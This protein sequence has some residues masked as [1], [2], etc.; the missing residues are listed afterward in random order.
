MIFSYLTPDNI[1]D[2]YDAAKTHTDRLTIPFPEFER[3]ARNRAHEGIDP[4]YPKTT[5]GTTASIIRKTPK[6]IIQQL[7]TGTVISEDEGWLGVI[8]EY[9]FTEKII[10]NANDEYHLIQKCWNIIEKGLTFGYGASYTPFLSHDGEFSPDLTL[11]YWGDIFFQPGKKSGYSSNY[12]FMRAWWQKEDIEALIDKEGKLAK[13]AKKRGEQYDSSWD[14]EAL[15]KILSAIS[16]K[17][18][19]AMTPSEEER[20]VSVDGIE[21]ITGFQK[22][23]G[24]KFF[25]FNPTAKVIVRTKTN[26]D[27]RGKMPIDFM[28]G[29]VDGSNPLGRGLVELIGGLQNLIDSDMQMYQYNRALMLA[30]PVIKRGSFS[31]NK[32]VLE[33]NRIIDLGTDPS[34]SVETMKIDTSAVI[35]YP[36]LYGLQKSQLLN[37]VNSPDTSISSDVGNP[38]FS[39]TTAGVQQQAQTVSVDDNYVSKM[40]ETWFEAWAET[41]INLYFA[42]RSGIEELQLNKDTAMRLRELPGFDQSLLSLDNKIRINYDTSTPALKFRVNPSTTKKKDELQQVQS[43]TNLL[44]MVM[45]YP[46]LNS[47]YGGPIDIEVLSR[48]IVINSGIDDPEQVA[49]EPTEAQKQ[50][51]EMQKNQV[52]PFSPM[53]DK[54]SIRM[55]FPDLP[56]AA[57]IQVLANAGVHVSPE[58]MMQGPVLDP[59][60]RGVMNPVSDPNALMPGGQLDANGQ[61]IPNQQAQGGGTSPIDLG[62]IYKQTTDPQVK[63]EIEQMAGLHPNPV[64]LTNQLETNAAQHTADQVGHLTGAANALMPQPTGPTT[65]PDAQSPMSQNT[66]NPDQAQEPTEPAQ[67]DTQTGEQDPQPTVDQLIQMEDAQEPQQDN[68]QETLS[69]TDKQII[70]H[71]QALQIPQDAIMQAIHMMEQ[72]ASADQVLQAIGV[73]HG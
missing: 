68:E 33:P 50:S 47:S 51:K 10:Q 19:R 25:T 37:L 58:E 53:F 63:A 27:P 2:R 9:I 28:Y 17:D 26:K 14:T 45:K 21:L 32:V 65:Q 18:A 61:P 12:V 16:H 3:I 1:Y 71:L 11:P 36:S 8:A 70:A 55:N 13:N 15:K 34:A 52:N 41:A 69:D 40:F 42:E 67:E 43:A 5:D 66:Q 23:V 59:N 22:G 24:A 46:M 72:G 57:Q 20:G 73:S 54:P 38:S 39:K 44:D 64:H 35:N 30:P 4:K 29:D 31:K 62:D 6:R 56:M 7:P 49:P 60:M 48:R